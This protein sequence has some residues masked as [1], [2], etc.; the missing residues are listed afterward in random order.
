M[1]VVPAGPSYRQPASRS[2]FTD[3]FQPAHDRF[4]LCLHSS[5]FC[6]VFSEYFQ[7]KP[8]RGCPKIR[9]L[10]VALPEAGISAHIKFNDDLCKPLF[11]KSFNFSMSW[12]RNNSTSLTSSLSLKDGMNRKP[13]RKDF[14]DLI[15]VLTTAQESPQL[16]GGYLCHF[17]ND[18]T[19]GCVLIKTF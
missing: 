13:L 19:R 18:D 4:L 17:W 16:P 2:V 8:T 11:I 5:G 10:N 7:A 3:F 1:S 12:L 9:P 14:F 15:Y 6:R